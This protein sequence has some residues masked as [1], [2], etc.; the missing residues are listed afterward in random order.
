[1]FEVSHM[2]FQPHVKAKEH[3]GSL[4]LSC[5]FWP[6]LFLG[7]QTLNSPKINVYQQKQTL[8]LSVN[9][10]LPSI[11]SSLSCSQAPSPEVGGTLFLST[12]RYWVISL[13]LWDSENVWYKKLTIY[14]KPSILSWKN[15]TK[16][17]NKKENPKKSPPI[18]K[19]I[20]LAIHTTIKIFGDLDLDPGEAFGLVH[21]PIYSPMPSTSKLLT[22][23]N[24]SCQLSV[25]IWTILP[26]LGLSFALV[27]L[28][29][30]LLLALK[31]QFLEHIQASLVVV[32]ESTALPR[33]TTP[34]SK[35]RV[36]FCFNVQF[37]PLGL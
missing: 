31:I 14:S 3:P 24:N 34:N 10:P 30:P 13:T 18:S 25:H 2:S 37:V 23:K 17:T 36:W 28:Q 27:L 4:F 9:S 32:R 1:M 15:K 33:P 22:Q 20:I 16:Q 11:I 35:A 29:L 8:N 12:V 5:V 19:L 26:F 21:A 7:S 6:G